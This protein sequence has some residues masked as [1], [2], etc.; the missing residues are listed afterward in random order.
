MDNLKDTIRSN[1]NRGASMYDTQYQHGIL[2]QRETDAWLSLLAELIPEPEQSILDVGTGTGFLSLLLA[3]QGHRVKAVD[4]SEEMLKK[5]SEKA[6]AASLSDRIVFEQED[7]ENLD[8]PDGQYDVVVNRHLLWTMPDPDRAISEWRRVLKPGEMLV[9]IDGDWFFEDPANNRK[10]FFG[11]LLTLLAERKN[12]FHTAP[13][14]VRSRLPM[15]QPEN[16]RTAP[17]RVRTAGFTVEVRSAPGIEAAEKAAAN[18][19]QRLLNPFHRIIILGRK[20]EP[21]VPGPSGTE[22]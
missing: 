18:L 14:S 1:W 16:A 3:R 13:S 8:E 10:I 17:D 4:L 11:K 12:L 21:T 15:T 20:T 7:A 19:R 22:E 5:A 9:I 6:Q 2:S